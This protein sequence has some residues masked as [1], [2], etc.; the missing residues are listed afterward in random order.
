VNRRRFWVPGTVLVSIL[1][2]RLCYLVVGYHGVDSFV[3][4]PHIES[5]A[6]FLAIVGFIVR[7]GTDASNSNRIVEAGHTAP[8]YSDA[9]LWLVL[10]A[11]SLALYWPALRIGL[12]S[13]DFILFQHALASDVSQVAPQLF[14]PLPLL[15][16]VVIVHLHGGP[17]TL[18]LLNIVIHAT[19]AYLTA[20]VVSG[21][22]PG[23]WWP[24]L[25]AILVLAAPLGPEA[26]AW[27]AGT[28]DLF[29]TAFM[30]SAVLIAR[31]PH[32]GWPDR[33]QLLA[34]TIGALLS[35][36]TAVVLPLLL[37]IDAA[38]RRSVS[39]RWAI[40]TVGVA[41]VAVAFG[42]LRLRSATAVEVSGFTRYRVQRLVFDSF[43]ALAAPWH[44]N[45]PF[46]G[47]IRPLYAIA[48]IALI[49][50]FFIN[51][52]PRWQ[53]AVSLGGS[54]WVIASI[55]PLLAF[56]QVGP[57]L[58]GSRYLYLATCGW[59]AVLVAA[60]SD[61]AARMPRARI[62]AASLLIAFGCAGAW[63]VGQ[64][65]KP[66]VRAAAM[67]DMVLVAA[68]SDIRLRSC[69]LAYVEALPESVDG[70]YLFANGA[71]EALGGAGV[72]AYARPGTGDCAFRW[73]GMTHT[74]VP[75]NG[76]AR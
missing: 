70:A 9:L 36:E 16:W 60:A 20:R 12:L 52:G 48:L 46:L 14:R 59:A 35:K 53:S 69:P 6:L 56:F 44:V 49:S 41:S 68:S 39:R 75:T 33:I 1:T 13:D 8:S 66:W 61:L 2:A 74:F 38:V 54:V 19:N 23:R 37:V 43:G 40:D 26:V 32:T 21:W 51:R 71:R 50:A 11:G 65:L 15:V 29:A 47:V 57:H 67:R 28:F 31:R 62:A 58:E 72:T 64:H 55:V 3:K 27:C 5:A 10:V 25:A 45:D 73:D 30:L 17:A 76:S 4:R 24:G 34:T 7:F 18:H 63:G 22:V 42:V